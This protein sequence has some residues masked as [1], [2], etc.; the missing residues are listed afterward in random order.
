MVT[1]LTEM[2]KLHLTSGGLHNAIHS[3][4]ITP[5]IEC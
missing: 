2:Y 1:T 5:K 3:V 4:L